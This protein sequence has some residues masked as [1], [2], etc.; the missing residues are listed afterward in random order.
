[1]WERWNG[2]TGDPAMNSFNH[3]AF[4]AV[5]QWL[6]Q[7]VAGIRPDPSAPGFQ[8]IIIHPR[9]DSR[10]THA[11]AEYDSPYGKI[12]SEWRTESGK[13][14]SLK[15]SIP[16][17]TSV[18]I[19]LPSRGNNQISVDGHPIGGDFEHL[20]HEDGF[21]IYQTGSGSYHFEVQ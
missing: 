9:P 16:A 14:F 5:G 1:M 11:N 10:L 12:S 17:N 20:G 6:Y 19:Y 2:D 3:Y 21:E 8:K 18:R 15:V 4:G 13:P 7:A